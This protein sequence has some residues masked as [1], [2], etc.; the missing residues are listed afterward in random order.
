[1]WLG[2]TVEEKSLTFIRLCRII[3][4]EM[5]SHDTAQ[6]SRQWRYKPFHHCNY[7]QLM[8]RCYTFGTLLIVVKK[9][10]NINYI[11]LLIAFLQ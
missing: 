5:L 8:C 6:T 7:L 2:L 4:C 1:M 11:Q 10:L 3:M 9:S